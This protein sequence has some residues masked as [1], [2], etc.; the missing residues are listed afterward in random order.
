MKRLVK[1][2]AGLAAAT[3]LL[4][5]CGSAT[6]GA[7]GGDGAKPTLAL[8]VNSADTDELKAMYEQFTEE[9]GYELDIVSFP[10]D[11]FETALLQRW[12]TGDR[13]D[14]LEW[15][16]NF[17]WV[18]AI[19]PAENVHDL[20]DEPFVERTLGGL[21]DNFASLDGVVY[22][23]VLNT[24]SSFGLYYNT[25]ILQA[26]GVTPPTTAD[27]VLA[28]CQAIK[29]YDPSIVPLQEAGG[30]QWTPLIMHGA[31]MADSLQ[32]GFLDRLIDRSARVDDADS[33]WRSSLEF[34]VE[35]RDA[36]CFNEDITTAQ[37]ENSAQVLLDGEAAMVSM[38]TGFI[39]QAIDASD[40]ETV[41]SLVGWTPWAAERPVVTSET[42]PI[43]TYYL[44]KTGDADREAGG[45]AFIDFMTGPAYND[46]IAA[47]KQ[48]PTLDGVETPDLPEP[49][50]QVQAAVSEYGSVP[51]IWAPLPG[52]TDLVLY[53][54]RIITGEDTPDSAVTLLQQQA[55]QGAEQARLP[56]WS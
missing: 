27:E 31:H 42:S 22:G 17:N 47:S 36:G 53:T 1:P 44:P 41:N 9:S 20:S 3:M 21:L 50:I 32:D 5:A 15:H 35:L 54:G 24:P 29:A 56:A 8:W 30:S 19:N 26:A 14:I 23:V 45:R 48:I 40:L 6:D 12:S 51:P 10:S 43:G 11:G 37:F 38:H 2:L 34:Y 7:S 33:P 49:W 16:G 4:T 28:A 18:A 46:Y 55:E 25:E 39:Q 13:P 52:I